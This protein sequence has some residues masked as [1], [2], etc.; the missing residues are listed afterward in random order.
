MKIRGFRIELGEIESLLTGHAGVRE[1]VVAA[2]EDGRGGKQLVAY[3]TSEDGEPPKAPELRGLLQAKLPEYMVPSAFVTLD[4]FPMTPNGKV[5]RKALPAPDLARPE[6]EKTFVAP[7][8]PTEEILTRIWCEVLGI[9]QAGMHDNFFE[10]G[11]HSLLAVRLQTCVEKEL[12]R[13][14]PLAAFFQAPTVAELT[15]LLAD[16]N[17]PSM[18]LHLSASQTSAERPPLFY[19]HFLTQAQRLA[20]HLGPEWPVYG[21]TAPFDEELRVWHEERRLAITMEELAARCLPIIQRVQPNGPYRLA[22]G[23]FGGALAFEVAIQLRRLGEEVALLALVDAFYNPG[24]RRLLFPGLRRWTYH[25]RRTLSEGLNYPLQK[26]RKQRELARKRRSEL[27]D[28]RAG[29]QPMRE[30]ENERIRLPQAE[31]M[32]QIQKPYQAKPYLGKAVLIRSVEE[33]FFGFDPGDTNGWAAV[34]QGGLQI[35]DLNCSHMAISEEPHIAKV[36]Q[37]LE[38]HLAAAEAG[39]KTDGALRAPPTPIM[40]PL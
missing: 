31:F 23:C 16:P 17:A 19:L 15:K 11:G 13:K 14:L 6:L 25:G 7:S 26:W 36:A 10:L 38:K 12:G 3:L 37:W 34:I 9:Q 29:E 28:M 5:D 27:N 24:C 33:P 30:A 8:T 1:A 32:D 39:S 4:R 21:F 20:K 35:E 2:R 40:P 18:G 22:G